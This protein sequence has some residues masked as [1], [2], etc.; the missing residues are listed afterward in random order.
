[1]ANSE[2]AGYYAPDGGQVFRFKIGVDETIYYF[3]M[4]FKFADSKDENT[5]LVSDVLIRIL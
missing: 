5:L 1:L 4:V 2:R 3:Q